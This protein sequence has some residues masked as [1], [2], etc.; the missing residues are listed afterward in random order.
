MFDRFSSEVVVA[1]ETQSEMDVDA[2]NST[3]LIKPKR[4]F[5]LAILRVIGAFVQIGL[6]TFLAF[7]KLADLNQNLP[8]D[9]PR[10]G[11]EVDED[12]PLW[13][14]VMHGIVWVR[15]TSHIVELIWRRKLANTFFLS[16]KKTRSML[17]FCQLSHYFI[18]DSPIHTNWSL[19]WT[20]ST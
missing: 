17:L 3:R 2:T 19:I 8:P 1:G 11:R 20:S 14:P 7:Q 5:S 4:T 6:F 9:A 10:Q 13:L 16:E 18:L 12:W 15:R